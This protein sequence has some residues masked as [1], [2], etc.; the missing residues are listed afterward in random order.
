VLIVSPSKT[1]IANLP[2]GKIPDRNDFMR[3]KG[4]DEER[5]DYWNKAIEAGR[6]LGEE[7]FEAV[8]SG[9]IRKMVVDY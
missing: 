2:Y 7:F 9:K 4:R 3:F 6:V 8:T 1:F 5:L